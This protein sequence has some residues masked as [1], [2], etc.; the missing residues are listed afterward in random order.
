MEDGIS[1]GPILLEIAWEVARKVGGIYT[2]IRTKVPFATR[3]WKDRYGLVGVYNQQSA[4]T[5]FEPVEPK[6]ITA[7]VLENL[8]KNHPGIKVHF[9]RW[10]IPGNFLLLFNNNKSS[11]ITQRNI[12]SERKDKITRSNIKDTHTFSFLIYDHVNICC[13]N[14]GQS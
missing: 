5:E 2:V 7:K 10:L 13:I 6:P 3:V 9:G 4:S 8:R 12:F 14:G 11:E 1:E